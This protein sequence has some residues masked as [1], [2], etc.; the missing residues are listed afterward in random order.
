[1]GIRDMRDEKPGVQ[2]K[3][4]SDSNGLYQFLNLNPSV[5]SLAVSATGFSGREAKDVTVFVGRSCL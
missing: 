1:M 4:Q 2:T 5:Y 3:T